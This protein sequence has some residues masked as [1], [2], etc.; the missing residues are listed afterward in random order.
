VVVNLLDNAIKFTPAGQR[1]QLSVRES[2]GAASVVVADSGIGIAA[3]EL[4]RVFEL[5]MQGPQDMSRT[6]GGMGVG[7]AIVKRLVELHGG[8]VTAASAGP[9]H[10][11][12]FTVTLPSVPAPATGTRAVRDEPPA[13]RR[14]LDVLVVEDNADAR[15]TL[16]ALLELKGHRAIGVAD[17]RTALE[18]IARV[19]PDLAFVDI[20]LPDVDGY[21]IAR[22]VRALP[23]MTS[24]VLVALTGYG[25]PAD[26]AQAFSAGFDLHVIK[27]ISADHLDRV[28]GRFDARTERNTESHGRTRQQIPG[29]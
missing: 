20:G 12:T 8:L 13:L 23:G 5:F 17:G 10:G 28:V 19:K 3:E 7:L 11:S 16:I 15:D 6:R 22:H 9:G 18:S 24:V 2:E 14:R 27:P 25:Q 21:A 4:P 1:I 29:A 26:E